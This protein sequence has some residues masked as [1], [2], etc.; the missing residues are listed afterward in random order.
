[1]IWISIFISSCVFATIAKK[2][3]GA[4]IAT[5]LINLFLVT[6][7][8]LI[9]LYFLRYFDA[10]HLIAIAAIT[11]LFR[12]VTISVLKKK[13]SC[14]LTSLSIGYLFFVAPTI[15]LVVNSDNYAIMS[16]NELFVHLALSICSILVGSSIGLMYSMD[17]HQSNKLLTGCLFALSASTVF[18]FLRFRAST[19]DLMEASIFLTVA[20]IALVIINFLIYF[21]YKKICSQ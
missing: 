13:F 16:F 19:Y 2:Q 11:E 5:I 17:L 9:F 1:M 18:E 21:Q 12:L 15:V 4:T 14:T 3:D 10:F 8:V 7:P 20:M 6:T